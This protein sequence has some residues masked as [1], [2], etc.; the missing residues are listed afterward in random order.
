MPGC[1]KLAKYP[2]FLLRLL[3]VKLLLESEYQAI[4][5]SA[6]TSLHLLAKKPESNISYC[7]VQKGL[8]PA[9]LCC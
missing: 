2:L 9:L 6:Q 8:S 5:F 4:L 3:S 7:L 1:P